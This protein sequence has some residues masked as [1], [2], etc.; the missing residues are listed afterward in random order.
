[1][2]K[3]T[4]QTLAV[5]DLPLQRINDT[6]LAHLDTAIATLTDLR[7][8]ILHGIPYTPATNRITRRQPPE[9]AARRR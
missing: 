4:R 5:G 2:G 7:Y 9:P 6:G 3:I 8:I 1:M